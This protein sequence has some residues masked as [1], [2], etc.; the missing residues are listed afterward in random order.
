MEPVQNIADNAVYFFLLILIAGLA[1]V[2][3]A[4]LA[5]FGFLYWKHRTRE[6]ESLDSVL[7]QVTMPADNEVKIDA[8]EQMGLHGR[9]TRLGPG[10]NRRHGGNLSESGFAGKR[11]RFR[12]NRWLI[13]L[14]QEGKGETGKMEM[15]FHQ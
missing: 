2:G 13:G 15:S 12:A 8:A 5:Y 9:P 1:A 11:E 10:R 3:L 7:L 4:V 6:K 14:V